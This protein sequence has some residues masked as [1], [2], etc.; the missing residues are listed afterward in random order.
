MTSTSSEPDEDLD[1]APVVADLT[2]PPRGDAQDVG[3][4]R[5]LLSGETR[6]AVDTYLPAAV[7]DGALV[8]PEHSFARAA[9]S[10]AVGI[11]VGLRTAAF[12]ESVDD[13]AARTQA[14]AAVRAVAAGHLVHGGYWGHSW[15]SSLVSG[16]AA[17]GA[18]LLWDDL[19]VDVQQ[20]V[21]RMVADEARVRY[22]APIRYLRDTAG[23][24]VTEGDTGAEEES[25]NARGMAAAVAMLP[26]HAQAQRWSRSLVLRLFAAYAKPSELDDRTLMQG[27]PVCSWLAGSNLEENGDLQ[28]H[29]FNPNPNYMRPPQ[30]IAALM[31]L[32]LGGRP[33]TPAATHGLLDLYRA[34]QRYYR[35]DGGLHYPVGIDF[36]ASNVILYANDVQMAAYGIDRANAVRWQRIHGRLVQAALRTDGRV[37]ESADNPG[38]ETDVLGKLGEAYLALVL[39]PQQRTVSTELMGAPPQGATPACSVATRTFPDTSGEQAVAASWT[40]ATGILTGRKEDSFGAG[41]H[42]TRLQAVRTQHRVAGSP[43][44]TAAHPFVD[45]PHDDGES[46]RAVRWARAGGVTTGRTATTFAPDLTLTRGQAMVMLW[47]ARGRPVAPDAGFSDVEG[48]VARAAA[49]AAT[50]GIT[51]GKA[52]GVFGPHAPVTRGQYAQWTHRQLASG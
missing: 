30:S 2:A 8:T 5:S 49:W 42:I 7:R 28:N 16:T 9:A 6:W 45:V 27:T 43:V 50:V 26:N 10:A 17:L 4:L 23:R 25:W 44:V 21:A 12:D 47:R 36:P 13:A 3:Q 32:Q 40:D 41:E 39:A 15:Q 51:T 31:L 29:N 46:D 11:A 24:Y 1:V 38:A 35:D 20:S 52:P 34:L 18:W 37:Q 19:A 14:V 22:A 48:E 33:V